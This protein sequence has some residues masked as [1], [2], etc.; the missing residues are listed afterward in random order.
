M[1]HVFEGLA[2]VL[3]AVLVPVFIAAAASLLAFIAPFAPFILTVGALGAAFLLLYDDYKTWAE[4]G[5]SLLDWKFFDNYIKTSKISTD[6]LGSAF[7]HRPR[8]ERGRQPAIT[9]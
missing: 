6:S 3:G 9:G 5:K 4:G 1:K 2:F 7:V 8:P